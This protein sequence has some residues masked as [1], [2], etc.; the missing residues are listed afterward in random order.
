MNESDTKKDID[1]LIEEIEISISTDLYT[2]SVLKKYK[3]VGYKW[4]QEQLDYAYR[5]ALE[6]KEKIS[7]ILMFQQFILWSLKKYEKKLEKRGFGATKLIAVLTN[8][9][10][11]K[12]KYFIDWFWNLI[13]K[14][15]IWQ[16]IK[17]IIS[18][19]L[20]GFSK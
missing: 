2:P 18:I 8:E 10:C 15:G 7:F 17:F 11:E 5:A 13:N 12:Y 16:P 4:D 3:I 6:T 19:L 1:E 20:I 14:L 9:F